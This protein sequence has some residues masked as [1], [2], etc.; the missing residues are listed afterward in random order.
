[1]TNPNWLGQSPAFLE[2]G[3]NFVH[4]QFHSFQQVLTC[5]FTEVSI[6]SLF[7][8]SLNFYYFKI[9]ISQREGKI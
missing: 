7:L 4:S 2:K 5:G 3:N 1:M 6:Y 8:C 9:Q